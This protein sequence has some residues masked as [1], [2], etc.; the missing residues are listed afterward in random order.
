MVTTADLKVYKST[1]FLGGAITGTQVLAATPNNIFTNVP[2]NELV[3][4][5][6]YYA[7]VYL[8]NTHATEKM[9]NFKLW[10][11]A[12]S[13]PHDTELKWGFDKIISSVQAPFILLDGVNDDVDCTND[14]T[15][16]SQGLT[17]FSFSMWIHPTN[18]NRGAD[19]SVLRHGNAGHRFRLDTADVNGNFTWHIE[20]AANTTDYQSTA[21]SGGSNQWQHIVCTYDSTLGSNQLKIYVNGVKGTDGTGLTETINASAVLFLGG[22]SGFFLGYIKDFRWWTTKA[23]SQAEIDS[24]YAGTGDGITPDYWLKMTEGTGNPIDFISGSKI[25]TLTGGAA[26]SSGVAQTIAN[27]YTAPLNVTWNSLGTKPDEPNVGEVSVS[28]TIPVW[29]WLHVPPNSDARLDDNAILSFAFDIPLLGTGTP[30][31]GDTGG[32]GGN[33]PPTPTDYKVAVMG[34][35]GCS[36]ITDA[37]K[38]LVVSEG[39][40]HLV[41]VGDHAY[42]SSSC[43]TSRFNSLKSIM[44]G[45]Y[46]NHEYSE[47]GGI[48]PYKTFFGH[49]KTYFTYKFQN[50]MFIVADTNIDCDPGSAQHTALSN[51]LVASQTDNTVTWRIGI[52]HHPWFGSGSDHPYNEFDQVQAFHTLFQNNGVRIVCTG[53]NHNFQRTFQVSYKSSSPT[54]PTIEDN[55]SPYSRATVGI[56][57]VVTGTGGHDSPNNLYSLGSQPGFQ[58]YQ[59]RTHNGIWEMVASNSGQTLTCSFVDTDGVRYDTFV[60]NA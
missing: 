38:A 27:K 44:N 11:S 25:G 15:L 49:T 51:A 2:K 54:S 3:I 58:A 8:K 23:L 41:S 52:M 13:F 7:E 9:D 5:E 28:E 31:G 56:I 40:N 14:A 4:G 43:W 33:P 34:D 55:S 47:S 29:L 22:D 16:W 37:V 19:T 59:N 36:S 32:T 26:W 48:T 10:L 20:N 6:D 46:G 12:K 18:L 50:I 21:S 60:I 1:N 53:H 17:K 45:A 42:A 57:H 24:I 30:G 39:Y 35:E